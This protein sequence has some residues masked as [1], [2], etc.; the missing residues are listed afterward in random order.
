[1]KPD[2]ALA[3]HRRL[4]DA[5]PTARS[6]MTPG[7]A[8]EWKAW[9]LALPYEVAAPAM[10]TLIAGSDFPAIH[11]FLAACGFDCGP[12]RYGGPMKNTPAMALLSAARDG[13]Y[14]LVRDPN[15]PHGWRSSREALPEPPRV[16]TPMPPEVKASIARSLAKMETR[17][18]RGR[19]D[20]SAL[21]VDPHIEAELAAVD[22]AFRAVS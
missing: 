10:T 12:E 3:L 22:A 7:N 1:M 21:T 2:E 16:R 4:V 11:Q 17:M 18:T 6:L 5:F 9:L 13:G 14:E 19:P 20:G 15:S 8:Q